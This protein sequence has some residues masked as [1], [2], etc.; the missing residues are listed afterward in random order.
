MKWHGIVLVI[1]ALLGLSA[2]CVR[3]ADSKPT[4]PDGLM[5]LKATL[6]GKVVSISDNARTYVLK[7]EKMEVVDGNKASDPQSAVGME[8][9]ISVSWE[10]D[11]KGNPRPVPAQV[12]YVKNL[13]PGDATWV[14]VSND[15][16]MR[17]HIKAFPDAK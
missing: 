11:A 15:D 5:G 6:S 17:L 12:A 13:K 2:I 9:T 3:A 4:L 7:V 8:L 16:G 1:V 10:A 14:T